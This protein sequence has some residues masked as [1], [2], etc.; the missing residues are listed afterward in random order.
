MSKRHQAGEVVAV[1]VAGGAVDGTGALGAVD[2][3]DDDSNDGDGDNDTGP[4]DHRAGAD[5][6]GVHEA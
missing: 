5:A 1:V 4:A 2:V 6:A 3:E